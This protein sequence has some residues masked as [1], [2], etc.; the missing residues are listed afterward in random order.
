M[1]TKQIKIDT[2]KKFFDT[3]L[4]VDKDVQRYKAQEYQ[5]RAK[6]EKL[7]AE[8]SSKTNQTFLKTYYSLLGQLL[9]SKGNLANKIGKEPN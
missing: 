7:E 6:I 8:D 3:E 4:S 2:P 9:R 5:L 1:S